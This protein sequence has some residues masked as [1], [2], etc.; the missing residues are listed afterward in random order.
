[1]V[2]QAPSTEDDRQPVEVVDLLA[3][4]RDRSID[5]RTRLVQ[6]V[7]DLFFDS[8][9]VLSDRERSHMT[10]ILRQLIHDVEKSVRRAVADR[11][12]SE[13]KAPSDLVVALA[14][15]EIEVAYPILTESAVLQDIELIEVMAH[16]SMKHQLAIS[17]R[18][19][20][21]ET[22]SGALVDTGDIDVIKSLL[23]NASAAISQKTMEYLVEESQRVDAYRNPLVHRHDLNPALAKRLYWW[24]SA[25][26]RNHILE[27]YKIDPTELEE[28]IESAVVDLMGRKR[29]TT[30]PNANR[31]SL[32]SRS[33][34]LAR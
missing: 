18:E 19:S 27:T 34:W 6:I 15:D 14:N 32:P 8:G 23:E 9:R 13:A 21:S 2:E 31:R 17:I 16:R 24:V 3:L 25:A 20:L 4:A 1:M 26:L 22:V 29:L 33:R 28:T 11:L 10:E 5:G 12:A 7:G 30:P